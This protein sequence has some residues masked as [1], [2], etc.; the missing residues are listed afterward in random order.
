MNRPAALFP[1]DDFSAALEENVHPRDWTNPRPA[2]RYNLVVIGGGTA[3]LVTAAGAAGLGARVALVE[4]KLLGGDCLNYGCV[5]SKA[6]LRTARAAADVRR[7]GSFGVHVDGEVVVGFPAA[8][9]RLRGLRAAIS[10]H[11]SAQRFR[12]LGVDVFFG[13]ARFVAADTVLVGDQHLSFRRAVIATGSRAAVPDIPGLADVGY[14][15]NETVFSLTDLPPRLAVIGGGPIGCELAQAFARCG[16]RVTL[17]G[18]HDRVLPRDD[19]EAAAIVDAA[20]RRDSVELLLQAKTTRVERRAN[21]KVLIVT[22]GGKSLE[23]VADDILIATGRRPNVEGLGLEV[24]G[25]RNDDRSGVH[26]NDRLQ[27]TNRRVFA[28]GDVC[29]SFKFTHAADAMARIV[30]QNALFFGRAKMSRLSIPWCT[31]TDPELAHVG[32]LPSAAHEQGIEVDTYVEQLRDVDRAVL[33]GETEG[34]VKVHVRRGSDKVVGATI[35]ARH[36]GEMI[37]EI[38]VA[39]A[40][41]A[42]LRKLARAIHPYPTQSEAIKRVADAYNRTRLTP[43]LKRWLDRWFRWTQ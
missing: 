24:V 31:Y 5:P 25:V 32:V 19:P 27:T 1:P 7:A 18:K 9:A 13:E 6:L 30:L 12:Q 33:D 21:E 8:M 10:P 2:D 40:A 16:S 15:T 23:V 20:L 22:T 14:L 3:G 39:M 43:R 41:R 34:F 36:A 35:V 38:T 26:V 29:S 42:G 11:D 17:I 28:A 37:S 4:R